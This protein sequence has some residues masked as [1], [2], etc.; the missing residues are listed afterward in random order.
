MWEK[1]L[2]EIWPAPLSVIW[3]GSSRVPKILQA[4]DGTLAQ[5]VPNLHDCPQFFVDVLRAC[6]TPIPTTSVNQP[7]E[8]PEVVWRDAQRWSKVYGCYAPAVVW[9][10]RKGSPSTIIKISGGSSF[11]LLRPGPVS[12]AELQAIIEEKNNA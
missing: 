3:N 2:R 10:N 11:E 4:P 5:R 9:E 6:K 8:T 7:G 1:V 12:E